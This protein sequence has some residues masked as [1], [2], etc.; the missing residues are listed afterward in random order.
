M[1]FITELKVCC[2]LIGS[3][4][5]MT[6]R[7]DGWSV[8]CVEVIKNTQSAEQVQA[9]GTA[10]LYTPPW[11]PLWEAPSSQD[12]VCMFGGNNSPGPF[13]SSFGPRRFMAL[14]SA[15]QLLSSEPLFALVGSAG[16]LREEDEM[17]CGWEEVGSWSGMGWNKLLSWP[18]QRT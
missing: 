7:C 5:I 17:G 1:F 11:P 16:S 10:V 9:F 4:R 13:T 2:F 18:W 15:L 12:P 3:C 8:V 6:A 14:S